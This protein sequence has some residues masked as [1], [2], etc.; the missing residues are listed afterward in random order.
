MPGGSVQAVP[1]AKLSAPL[2]C[3]LI[4][5]LGWSSDRPPPQKY[6]ELITLLH[7]IRVRSL[8]LISSTWFHSIVLRFR[9]GGVAAATILGDR[10]VSLAGAIPGLFP[11]I[12]R[13][14]ESFHSGQAEHF[15]HQ[16]DSRC[17]IHI[18]AIDSLP[19][20]V[21]QYHERQA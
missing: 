4:V 14:F 11:V 17:C 10:S 19:D 8:A 6:Q 5:C 1:G 15:F 16:K 7:R 21:D 9:G 3:S 13:P 12:A 18:K 2:I 20:I